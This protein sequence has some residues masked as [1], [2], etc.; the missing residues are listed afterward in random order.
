MVAITGIWHGASCCRTSGGCR[1]GAVCVD[2]HEHGAV[3]H[4]QP[5]PAAEAGKQGS[6]WRGGGAE[7]VCCLDVAGARCVRVPCL[8]LLCHTTVVTCGPKQKHCIYGQLMVGRAFTCS[9]IHTWI[10]CQVQ[11]PEP[12]IDMSSV[13]HVTQHHLTM[14]AIA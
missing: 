4:N 13:R 7:E 14:V 1:P 12:I 6:T 8:A 11:G 3:H 2:P 10:I 5:L 9:C